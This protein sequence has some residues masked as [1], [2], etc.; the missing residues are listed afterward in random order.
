MARIRQL[1]NPT[2]TRRL[3]RTDPGTEVERPDRCGRERSD[4]NPWAVE[5]L[6]AAGTVHL[7]W[8]CP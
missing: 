6:T 8:P 5:R 1:H 7:A 2:I 4:W 3:C